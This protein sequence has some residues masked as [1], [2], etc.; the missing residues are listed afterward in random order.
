MHHILYQKTPV[1]YQIPL[2]T[3][4][5]VHYGLLKIHKSNAPFPVTRHQFRIMCNKDILKLLFEDLK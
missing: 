1:L 5:A 3:T 2:S 4:N